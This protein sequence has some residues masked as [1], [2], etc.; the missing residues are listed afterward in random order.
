V[1][2]DEED[3]NSNKVPAVG[4]EEDEEEVQRN[5]PSKEEWK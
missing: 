4:E 5:K 3:P 1:D 2:L